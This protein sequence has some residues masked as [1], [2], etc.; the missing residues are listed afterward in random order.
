M[1]KNDWK[2][3]LLVKRRKQSDGITTN[4]EHFLLRMRIAIPTNRQALIS[5]DRGE[6]LALTRTNPTGGVNRSA[7]T[8][9][10]TRM[11]GSLSLVVYYS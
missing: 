4:G 10:G 1:F 7:S 8:Y 2:W 3:G 6:R 5:S 9:T 11:L